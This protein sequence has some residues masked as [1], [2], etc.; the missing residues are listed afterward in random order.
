LLPKALAARE[1]DEEQVDKAEGKRIDELRELLAAM[2]AEFAAELAAK[3][4]ETVRKTLWDWHRRNA[5]ALI[6]EAL[7]D[8]ENQVTKLVEAASAGSG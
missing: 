3:V 6:P 2:N 8:L 7:T 5:L 4:P 1:S